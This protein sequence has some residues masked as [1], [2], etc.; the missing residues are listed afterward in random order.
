MS[1]PHELVLED[2]PLEKVKFPNSLTK[3][4][5]LGCSPY[6]TFSVPPL[7]TELVIR[8]CGITSIPMLPAT[9]RV[10]D[11]SLN[12]IRVLGRMPFGLQYLYASDCKIETIMSH[13]LRVRTME[14]QRN[15]LS[16]FCMTSHH[17]EHLYLNDNQLDRCKLKAPNLVLLDVSNN[18]L[19]E[20][21]L[22]P[23][24]AIVYSS[25]NK[26]MRLIR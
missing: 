15:R 18:Q 12:P 25:G 17:I 4:K 13:P 24:R 8:D 20:L 2:V 11:V 9:L 3:L 5:L 16:Y 14:L 21:H 26:H 7:L 22:G 10:L 23:G 6:Q 19:V 1:L